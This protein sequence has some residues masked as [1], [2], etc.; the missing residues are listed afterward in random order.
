MSL[1]LEN[2]R[3]TIVINIIFLFWEA[4]GNV[5]WS[6]FLRNKSQNKLQ[7]FQN[8]LLVYAMPFLGVKALKKA[9]VPPLEIS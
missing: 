1:K 8:L 6:G 9:K 7:T 5:L 2:M 3:I 4:G